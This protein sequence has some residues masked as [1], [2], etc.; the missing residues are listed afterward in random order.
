MPKKKPVPGKKTPKDVSYED[1]YAVE[2]ETHDEGVKKTPDELKAEMEAG[3]K[4][5]EVYTEEGR[6]KLA[7][8][9]EV[10]PFEQGFM[11]GAEGRGEQNCCAECG[12]L[13]GE[14]EKEIIEREFDGEL[15][16]FCSE[17]HAQNYAKKR[18][19]E[20]KRVEEVEEK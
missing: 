2:D 20:E 3:K 17:E 1:S 10:E 7:E 12:K 6:E 18:E 16:W 9:D 13:L 15:K 19:K 4:S 8:D 5:E 14:E 11:E